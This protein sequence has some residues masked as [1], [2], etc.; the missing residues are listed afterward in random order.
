MKFQINNNN[1][2][3][4]KNKKKLDNRKIKKKTQT[5]SQSKTNHEKSFLE[6]DHL[7]FV[8]FCYALR[9]HQVVPEKGGK[10]GGGGG[11][12]EGEGL[13]ERGGGVNVCDRMTCQQFVLSL[14][15]QCELVQRAWPCLAHS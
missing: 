13:R 3:K 5:K 15:S 10:G 11:G 9:H 6:T 1:F 8:L 4:K 12:G 2:E 14:L 7:R